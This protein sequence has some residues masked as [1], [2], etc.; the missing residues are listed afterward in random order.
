MS[1]EKQASKKIAS[2]CWSPD[3]ARIAVAVREIEG[4]RPGAQIEVMDLDGGH[5]RTVPLPEGSM[6]EMPDWR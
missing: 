2:A 6:A 3:G 1:S 5:R 4:R